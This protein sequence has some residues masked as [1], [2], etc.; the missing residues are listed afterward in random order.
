MTTQPHDAHT[1]E[2]EPERPG[3]VVV[4]VDGSEPSSRALTF[5][6]EE[7]RLRARP[8]RVVRAWHVPPLVYEAYIP[9]AYEGAKEASVALDEQVRA[10]LGDGDL[11]IER[12]VSEGPAAKVLLEAGAGADLLVVGSRGHGGFGGLLLGS[13][14]TQ[15]VH[16]AH[17]PVVVVRP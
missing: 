8:L 10:V 15:V 12:V 7:A 1:V 13:V 6:A 3:W 5:A 17:C 4:G 2:P 9:E 14:S 16:H 11:A